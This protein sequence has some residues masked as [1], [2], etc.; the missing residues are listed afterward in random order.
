MRY[1]E[2]QE[3][4]AIVIFFGSAALITLFGPMGLLGNPL[5]IPVPESLVWQI[6]IG[7]LHLIAIGILMPLLP[8]LLPFIVIG[9]VIAVIVASA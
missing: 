5:G 9:L 7:L 3:T 1:R 6:V 4:I 8:L 2:F